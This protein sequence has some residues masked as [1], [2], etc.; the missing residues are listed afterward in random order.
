MELLT[1]AHF[2]EAESFIEAFSFKRENFN[3]LFKSGDR[4]L[5]ITGE[6]PFE[7]ITLL[8]YLIAQYDISKIINFGIVGALAK[9]F[10]IGEIVNVRTIY[11]YLSK[12]YFQSFTLDNES[13]VDC[14]TSEDRVLETEYATK[15]SNFA[16]IVDRELWPMAKIANAHKIELSSFKLISDFANG[17]INCF[18]IQ[19]MA[20]DFSQKLLTYYKNNFTNQTPEPNNEHVLKFK[21]SFSQK[22]RIEKLSNKLSYEQAHQIINQ[23]K[24]A[25]EC[26]KSLEYKI[27]PI[28]EKIEN[29]IKFIQGPFEKIGANIYFD[30][31]KENKNVK[32]T[33]NINS[34]KNIENL[35][36]VLSDF[37]YEQI[38]DFYNGNLDV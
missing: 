23:S 2:K 24:N 31:K 7:S 32:V 10:K 11:F 6:G 35:I 8:P 16:H 1:C 20:S 37:R 21:A 22:K 27:N 15:L 28:E 4:L 30:Q 13:K 38:D 3:N 12:P 14:I 34:Q 17:E 29:K 25:N 9:D 18:D 19:S 5:L 26:I 33:M 36:N